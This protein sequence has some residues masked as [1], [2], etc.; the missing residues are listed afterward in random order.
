MFQI[1]LT[2]ATV[3]MLALAVR[4]MIAYFREVSK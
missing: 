4:E 1:I 2:T 3:A